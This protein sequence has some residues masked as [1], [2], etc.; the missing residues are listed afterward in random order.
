[1]ICAA[2]HDSS[3]AWW[4]ACER[5]TTLH[6]QTFAG[7][8]LKAPIAYRRR[9]A[10]AANQAH[11]RPVVESSPELTHDSSHRPA[12]YWVPRHTTFGDG[13]ADQD[14]SS[15]PRVGDRDQRC[16]GVWEDTTG[17]AGRCRLGAGGSNASGTTTHP[18][19]L[20]GEWRYWGRE[21]ESSR[22]GRSST[23]KR[24][25][26][27]LLHPLHGR[28]QTIYSHRDNGHQQQDERGYFTT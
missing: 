10:H 2:I 17:H 6:P 4:S 21:L 23:G 22:D 1:M 19:L 7:P 20:V 11:H 16:P 5:L 25:W 28:Q 8:N 15:H 24:L 3:W 13:S 27:Q 9:R 14:D 26:T 12:K 18:G